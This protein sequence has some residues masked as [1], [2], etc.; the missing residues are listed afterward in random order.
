MALAALEGDSEVKKKELREDV[1]VYGPRL[2]VLRLVPGVLGADDG[3]M[4]V[5][6][7]AGREMRPGAPLRTALASVLKAKSFLTDSSSIASSTFD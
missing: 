4:K 7:K 6:D 2:G 5:L 3:D 1:G